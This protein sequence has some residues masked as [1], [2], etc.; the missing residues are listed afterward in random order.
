MAFD[1]LPWLSLS[2]EIFAQLFIRARE[3]MER[4][5]RTA[6]EPV[7]EFELSGGG[8]ERNPGSGMARR[9]VDELY[10]PIVPT[11]GR[12][13]GSLLRRMPESREL[14]RA[15]LSFVEDFK[16]SGAIRQDIQHKTC[17]QTEMLTLRAHRLLDILLRPKRQ[18]TGFLL[19]EACT[20]M[21]PSVSNM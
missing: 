11:L 18:G 5:A 16:G 9:V 19:D 17:R 13:G 2:P 1:A 12:E 3:R 15:R 21:V 6:I 8:I 20:S 14:N 4:I 10:V 7:P